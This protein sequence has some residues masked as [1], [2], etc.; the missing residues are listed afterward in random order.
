MTDY[1][2]DADLDSGDNDGGGDGD[3]YDP[4]SAGNWTNAWK[5]FADCMAG[6]NGSAPAAGDVVFCKGTDTLG[7][8]TV[9]TSASGSVASGFITFI[10]C[11]ADGS[12]DGTRVVINGDGSYVP[13]TNGGHSFLWFENFE[14]T[15]S[16]G[17]GVAW[18][19]NGD[20]CVFVNCISHSNSSGD[21]FTGAS[22]D[23]VLFVKCQAYSN[24]DDGYSGWGSACRFMLCT[25]YSNTD[26]GFATTSGYAVYF[27]SIAHDNGANAG[28]EG[29]DLNASDI[30]INCI[31]DGENVGVYLTSDYGQVFFSRLTNNAAHAN[32]SNEI[33]IFGWNVFYN[34]TADNDLDLP[35]AWSTFAARTYAYFLRD[36]SLLNTNKSD[37]ADWG[38][39]T[40]GDADD[41][42]NDK[43]GPDDFNLKASREYNG[44]GT[45]VVAMNIGS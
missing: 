45:D 43:A 17:D 41:G 39:G 37:T 14:F 8:A 38:S 10:G 28:D 15:N 40:I 42:Y 36:E 7:S 32:L 29:F 6:T 16:S 22:G 44:D 34:A 27:G 31:A 12:V 18:H 20:Y 4:T 9:T 2:V 30:M 23:Q 21:G 11:A 25:A 5:T 24:G 33:G 3:A 13:L 19:T 26:T 1:Y 35:D